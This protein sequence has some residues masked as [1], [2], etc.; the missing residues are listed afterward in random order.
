MYAFL[1][2][3]C[4]ITRMSRNKNLYDLQILSTVFNI[5]SIYGIIT[6]NCVTSRKKELYI[7]VK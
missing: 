6:F 5:I 4:V 2:C 3:I 1:S 7:I